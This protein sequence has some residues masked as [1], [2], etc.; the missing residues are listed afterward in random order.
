MDTNMVAVP[1]FRDNNMAA[2][3]SHHDNTLHRSFSQ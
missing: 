2:M 3:M 1:L